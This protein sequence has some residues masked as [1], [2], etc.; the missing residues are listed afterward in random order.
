MCGVKKM[1]AR[2][3]MSYRLPLPH[4]SINTSGEVLPSMGSAVPKV[5]VLEV[6][7]DSS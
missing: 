2:S 3:D 6:G 4:Y 5:E 1:K 7:K